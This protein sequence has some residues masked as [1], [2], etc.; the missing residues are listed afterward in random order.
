MIVK[1][2]T[3]KGLSWVG[4]LAVA[5]LSALLLP[6]APSWGQKDDGDARKA[7]APPAPGSSVT[8]AQY[9][10]AAAEL[11]DT[12]MKLI[13][14]AGGPGPARRISGR[15]TRPKPGP[16]KERLG[17]QGSCEEFKEKRSDVKPLIEQSNETRRRSRRPRTI[18]RDDP[19][20]RRSWSPG[21]SSR[22]LGK[23]QWTTS[24]RRSRTRSTSG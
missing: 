19:V 18:A 3:P 15:G 6:L 9:A 2:K 11:F 20:T 24:G 8:E 5:G 21:S 23:Q 12:D 4:R 7:E 14:R 22:K 1:A 16:E 17:G 10:R 13:D